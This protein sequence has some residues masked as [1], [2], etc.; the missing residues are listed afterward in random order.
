MRARAFYTDTI[1]E[2]F[3]ASDYEV[4][5]IPISMARRFVE[6]Y[7]YSGAMSNT[8]THLHGLYL[9][10]G[11][12]LLGVAAWLPPTRV[13]AETVNKDNWRRVLSLSRLCVHPLVPTNGAS[14]LM[15]ASMRIIEAEQKWVSLVTYADT[16]KGHTGAIYRAANWEYAGLGKPQPRW[17]DQ[18]GRQVAKRATKTRTKAEME[19]AGYRMVG[20]FAKHKFVKHLR[21]R[22]KPLM[23]SGQLK[24][25]EFAA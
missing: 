22:R 1:P 23:K 6:R 18:H 8:G 19:A 15:A 13:A 16:F 14:F 11:I 3:K 9:K 7:H 4:K 12:Q 5:P 24:F 20:S 2:V 21:Q 17:E 25:E 10:N